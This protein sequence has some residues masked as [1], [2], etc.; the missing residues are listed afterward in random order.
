[1]HRVPRMH[2]C[3]QGRERSPAR[4]DAHLRQVGRRRLVPRGAPRLPGDPLQPVRRCA[5]HRCLP[6][7]GDVPPP[8]R[9]RRLRQVDLHRLQG[10]HGRLPLRRHLHQPAGPLGREVQHVRP[11]PRD[12][13]RT[14]LRQCL[15]DGGDPRRRRQRRPLTCGTAALFGPRPGAQGG[16]AD[17]AGCAL[18]RGKRGHL[19]SLGGAAPGWWVVRLGSSDQRRDPLGCIR[20]SG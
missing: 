8:G 18:P 11:P 7:T 5:V 20:P 6:D 9:D 15:P 16:E 10:V 13:S 14:G 12:R 1:M 2:D 3:L 4:R 19:G 17:L